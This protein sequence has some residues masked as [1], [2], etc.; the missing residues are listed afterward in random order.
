ML[1]WYQLSR[2]NLSQ[3]NKIVSRIWLFSCGQEL[4]GTWRTGR[5][6]LCCPSCHVDLHWLTNIIIKPINPSEMSD[7]L[8]V[9]SGSLRQVKLALIALAGWRCL[10]RRDIYRG[11]RTSSLPMNMNIQLCSYRNVHW[12]VKRNSD[13]YLALASEEQVF[14]SQYSSTTR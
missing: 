13:I 7:S 1:P 5:S 14:G 4:S 10:S 6:I 2:I 9:S 12:S 8:T 3:Q 11:F